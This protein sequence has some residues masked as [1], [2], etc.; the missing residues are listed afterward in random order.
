MV[1]IAF[2]YAA[3]TVALLLLLAPVLFAWNWIAT[4]G[5]EMRAFTKVFLPVL[6]TSEVVLFALW[7]ISNPNTA[8]GGFLFWQIFG[9]LSLL[10]FKDS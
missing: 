8:L 2:H 10:G 1:N 5:H 3:N 9:P 7:L 6:G 4:D